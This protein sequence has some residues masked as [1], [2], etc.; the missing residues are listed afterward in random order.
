M[1]INV[2]YLYI[3]LHNVLIVS[4]EDPDDPMGDATP[5][6]PTNTTGIN[7]Y[8]LV[9][10]DAWRKIPER[11]RRKCFYKLREVVRD[12]KKQLPP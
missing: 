11:N 8:L 9:L 7:N 3:N 10:R 5:A 4:D 1:I 2:Q 6:R 12:R